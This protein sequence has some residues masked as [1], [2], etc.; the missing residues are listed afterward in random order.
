MFFGFRCCCCFASQMP[1]VADSFS[2]GFVKA[3][4]FPVLFPSWF[5]GLGGYTEAAGC[6]GGRIVRCLLFDLPRLHRSQVFS[7]LE[8]EGHADGSCTS[9]SPSLT[10][11]TLLC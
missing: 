5:V 3:R 9:D 6:G 11:S 8:T 1:E 10:H 4:T 2:L 7:A